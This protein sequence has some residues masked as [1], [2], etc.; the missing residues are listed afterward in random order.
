M[1]LPVPACTDLHLMGYI[2]R[3]GI[4]ESNRT[5]TSIVIRT[6]EGSTQF[7]LYPPPPIGQRGLLSSHPRQHHGLSV[8]FI[9]AKLFEDREASRE[10]SGHRSLPMPIEATVHCP[11]SLSGSCPEIPGYG[12][13]IDGVKLP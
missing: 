12:G 10:P 1:S 8:F 2:S 4:A 6:P 13:S 7:I 3:N 5:C 11:C 9:F